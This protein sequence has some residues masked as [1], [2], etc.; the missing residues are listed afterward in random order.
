CVALRQRARTPIF[1]LSLH[2]ALPICRDALAG[3][4]SFAESPKDPERDVEERVGLV[5]VRERGVE[6]PLERDVGRESD[7][8]D[9]RLGQARRRSEE[10]TSEL[11]SR[12]DLICRVLL[13]SK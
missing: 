4:T 7:E 3:P 1:T 11:Q 6:A 2:D 9:S 5:A 10:H 13:E 8:L 12:F